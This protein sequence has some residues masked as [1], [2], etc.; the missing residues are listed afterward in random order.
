[1]KQRPHTGCGRVPGG[2]E[3][4]HSRCVPLPTQS[5]LVHNR[6]APLPTQSELVHSRCA[7]LPTQ[8]ELVHSRCAPL[9]TQSEL[10]H[11]QMCASSDPVGTRPQL[12][13]ASSNP[14]GTRPQ[15]MCA[16]SGPVGT[17]PQPMCAAGRRI[18]EDGPHLFERSEFAGPPAGDLRG[19]C[20]PGSLPVVRGDQEGDLVAGS[21]SR[22]SRRWLPGQVADELLRGTGYCARRLAVS[23]ITAPGGSV[24]RPGSGW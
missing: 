21:S 17:R 22:A 5:E 19:A 23:D 20:A 6:C 12:M 4:V 8:S 7:A 11:S 15:P 2:A 16:P 14:V 1:M 13:C 3:V 18:S 9:P 24:L 10:L